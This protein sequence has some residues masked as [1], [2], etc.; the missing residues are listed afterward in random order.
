[1]VDVVLGSFY[2]DEG[3][4]KII[5]YLSTEADISVRCTG[6]ESA[7]HIVQINNT[8]YVLKLLPTGILNPNVVPVIANGVVSKKGPADEIFPQL[9]SQFDNTCTFR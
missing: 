7:G 4:G 1:M 6:G 2:G 9:M 5:D 3:K 8:K